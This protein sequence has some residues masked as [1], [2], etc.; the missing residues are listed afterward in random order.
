MNPEFAAFPESEHAERLT[1]A[2]A[3]LREAGLRGCICVAPENLFYLSG[4]D[5]M[6]YFNAQALIVSA[7]DDQPVTLV[8]RNVDLPLVRETAWIED[9][10]TYHLHATDVAAIVAG[11]ARERGLGKG[12]IGMDLQTYALPGAYALDLTRALTPAE[13]VDAT[14]LLGSLQDFKSDREMEY[15]R[16]SARYANVGLETARKTLRAG[17]TEIELSAAIEGA[18][19]TAGCDYPALPPQI[20]SGPRSAGGHAAPMDRTIRDGDL[21]HVEFAG[22]ARR[23]HTVALHT[24]A[25][26]AP[27]PR[28]R[29][30]Y[31]LTLESLRAGVAACGPG[32]P[33]A[34]IEEASLAPLRREGLEDT[35]M[36]RFGLG[37]GVGYPP[38]WVG[39]FQID[40]F[41]PQILEPGMLFYVHACI[42]LVDEGIGTVQGA[43]YYV[44][45]TG[46]E[47]LVGGGDVELEIV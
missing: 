30:I 11:V 28:A 45:P 7:D 41:S 43:T 31:A 37:L 33:V 46:I 12:P 3:K 32:A 39:T 21:I 23:Y 6:A 13:V 18:M 27:S 24:M 44:T 16:E 22:C 26:G 25:V 38:V 19:R 34:A 8:A 15:V 10:R 35:A 1:R 5:S 20:A 14:V 17:I 29:E 40:R 2:R 47:M 9:I 42:E 36:M 4:Y